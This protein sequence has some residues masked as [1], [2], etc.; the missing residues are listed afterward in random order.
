[1]SKN[2]SCLQITF[3]KPNFFSSSLEL[4]SFLIISINRW[5][6]LSS[7][8]RGGK[9]KI[10]TYVSKTVMLQTTILHK[11]CSNQNVNPFS[12]FSLLVLYKLA[13]INKQSNVFCYL[14]FFNIISNK[15][16]QVT[17]YW[18]ITQYINVQQNPS[19]IKELID[20]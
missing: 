15:A 8:L 6:T 17:F 18:T 4:C 7:K 19:H 13:I 16:F 11:I 10:Q 5:F 12:L 3:F 20:K 14:K 1:M 9:K 2:R